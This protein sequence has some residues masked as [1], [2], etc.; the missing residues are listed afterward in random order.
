M[1]G[2]RQSDRDNVILVSFTVL[3]SHPIHEEAVA[4]FDRHYHTGHLCDEGKGTTDSN[5]EKTL[6]RS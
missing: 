4:N 2:R 3:V 6:Q 5:F 1:I